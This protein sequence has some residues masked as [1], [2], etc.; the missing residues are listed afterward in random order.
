MG[1]AGNHQSAWPHRNTIDLEQNAS[2]SA[3]TSSETW[4]YA[5]Y[6]VTAVLSMNRSGSIFKM[7]DEQRAGRP[8]MARVYTAGQGF[9]FQGYGGLAGWCRSYRRGRSETGGGR[10]GSKSG[11]HQALDGRSLGDQ[12]QH[13]LSFARAIIDE[14]HRLAAR[15]GARV[16]SRRKGLCYGVDG[17]VHSV[18]DRRLTVRRWT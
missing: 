1:H 17:L 10:A 11:H 6:G 8:T 15:S 7:R 4:Q 18:R 14:A 3:R 2:S 13:A 9:V 16:L 5:S 12:A